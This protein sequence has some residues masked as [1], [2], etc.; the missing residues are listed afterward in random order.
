MSLSARSKR[1]VAMDSSNTVVPITMTSLETAQASSR[2]TISEQLPRTVTVTTHLNL[3]NADS[4]ESSPGI[5]SSSTA[6]GPSSPQSTST[7]S[8]GSLLSGTSASSQPVSNTGT[9]QSVITTILPIPPMASPS[10]PS[11]SSISLSQALTTETSFAVPSILSSPSSA[12]SPSNT[13]I[14]TP[15]NSSTNNSTISDNGSTTPSSYKKPS[16]S[17]NSTPA[18]TESSPQTLSLMPLFTS[19]TS[20]TSITRASTFQSPSPRPTYSQQSSLPESSSQS[21]PTS[22]LSTTPTTSSIPP[23]PPLSTPSSASQLPCLGTYSDGTIC[24]EMT[25]TQ[26]T[27]V[28]TTTSH[29]TIIQTILAGPSTPPSRSSASDM[30]C[31]GALINNTCTDTTT[32]KVTTTAT[33][34]LH[35]ISTQTIQNVSPLLSSPSPLPLTSSPTTPSSPAPTS[36]SSASSASSEYF[37][38]STLWPAQAVSTVSSYS[39]DVSDMTSLF[40]SP[41]SHAQHASVPSIS[42][43]ASLS[44]ASLLQLTTVTNSEFPFSTLQW[45]TTTQSLSQLTPSHKPLHHPRHPIPLKHGNR[46]HHPSPADPIP[47]SNT[48]PTIVVLLLALTLILLVRYEVNRRGVI[49]QREWLR[50]RGE[51]RRVRRMGLGRRDR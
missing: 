26:V 24:V 39:S 32:M 20:H 8:A 7:A 36:S 28:V 18:L 15:Q 5:M 4:N 3:C 1:I 9:A 19:A 11:S 34:T 46:N 14:S 40:R 47:Q 17:V 51:R 37:D 21:T 30:P 35:P 33:A 45:N 29:P 13:A 49:R 6:H 43:T 10:P 16:S 27:A 25:T 2:A 42:G 23:L 50:R 41:S 44:L 38:S 31:S 12:L 48:V 22:L